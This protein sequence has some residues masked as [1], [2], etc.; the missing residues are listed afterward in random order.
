[1]G[2]RVANRTRRGSQAKT[3]T[4]GKN[5]SSSSKYKRP[6][7]AT[8]TNTTLAIPD[9]LLE[10]ILLG[11]ESSLDLI[12]AGSVCKRWRS[13]VADASFLRRFR[14]AHEPAIA[15]KFFNNDGRRQAK[16]LPFFVPSPATTGDSRHFALEFLPHSDVKSMV[17]NIVDSRGSLLLMEHYNKRGQASDSDNFKDVIVCEP[18][19]RRFVKISPPCTFKGE[20][21]DLHISICHIYL[22]DGDGEGGGIGL[23][24]FRVLCLIHTYDSRDSESYNHVG[25]LR[26][27][28]SHSRSTIHWESMFT[29]GAPAT[30][31]SVYCYTGGRELIAIDRRSTDISTLLL[32]D[33]DDWETHFGDVY[34]TGGHADGDDRVVFPTDKGT[35]KVYVRTGGGCE[36][37]LDKIVKLSEVTRDLPYWEELF[38]N[39]RR[40]RANICFGLG[41]TPLVVVSRQ[42]KRLWKFCLDVETLELQDVS[43]CS[44][45]MEYP[46]EFPWPPVLRACTDAEV[47]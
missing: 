45:E 24:N 40:G 19:T 16:L 6:R 12:H 32:P 42:Y 33:I 22:A 15:G 43:G 18:L 44:F 21:D 3:M 1:M 46:C 39:F 34:A 7:F 10:L 5:E 4:M 27:D 23:T 31:A 38:Q 26:S 8:A 30:E 11:L 9:E 14:S 41:R 37:K 25:V 29:I 47:P 20:H 35:I 28:G 13:I 2:R 17:W 36:L